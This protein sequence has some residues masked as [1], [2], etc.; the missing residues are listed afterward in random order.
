MDIQL[1]DRCS[2]ESNEKQRKELADREA[3]QLKWNIILD[4]AASKGIDVKA[5]TM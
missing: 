4:Q 5:L 2:S 3:A 1:Y